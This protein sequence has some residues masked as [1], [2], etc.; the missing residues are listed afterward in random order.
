MVILPQQFLFEKVISQVSDD[1][2]LVM[3]IEIH[4]SL[5]IGCLILTF[6]L[7]LFGIRGRQ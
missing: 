1:G 2:D 4:T 6:I 7:L 5:V 3:E